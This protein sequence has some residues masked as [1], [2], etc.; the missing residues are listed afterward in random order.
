M[1][2]IVDDLGS[3]HDIRAKMADAE[4]FLEAGG[5]QRTYRTPFEGRTEAWREVP[6]HRQ[7]PL[8]PRLCLS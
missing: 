5:W 2:A 7:P 8:P 1:V 3:E 6:L 4:G